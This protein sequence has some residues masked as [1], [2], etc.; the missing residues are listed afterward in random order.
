[1]LSLL[2]VMAG[3]PS[4]IAPGASVEKVLG[5]MRFTEGPC[6]LRD[7][8]LVFSDI[9]ANLIYSL[10]GDKR[11]AY[12]EPSE[13]ANGNTLDRQ[14]RLISCLHGSRRVVRQEKDGKLTVL[15]D[16]FNGKKLNSPND[17]WVSRRGRIYFTDPPY[18]IRPADQEQP[19]NGVY[20][21]DK[22]KLTLLASDFNRP[23]G[24]VLSPDEKT[25]YV[26]DTAAGHIRS[27]PV[28]GDGTLGEGKVFAQTPFPDGIRVDRDGRLWTASGNG[29]NV[30]SPQGQ[31]LQVIPI[32]EAPANLAFSRKGDTLWV[33]ARTSLYRVK[34][35]VKGVAP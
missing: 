12:R 34:V 3:S 10:K 6:E 5:G 20:L 17:A 16:T 33:T 7:G 4:F 22:G 25:L 2:A 31:V 9:P 8:T 28:K 32:P 30:I 13:N 21:L 23:N 29:V 11:T 1:M 26:A 18:G 27:F 35:T 24:I 15:A 14:G 19:H